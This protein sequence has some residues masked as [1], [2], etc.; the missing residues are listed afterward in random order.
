MEA[1][2]R[3][4]CVKHTETGGCE[5]W[6]E[7]IGLSLRWGWRSERRVG[8]RS[9]KWLGFSGAQSNAAPP[10][11]LAARFI[12]LSFKINF[13]FER[14]RVQKW[15]STSCPRL[16]PVPPLSL[17]FRPLS[18]HCHLPCGELFWNLPLFFLWAALICALW[19]C[20]WLCE[21]WLQ[22]RALMTTFY[23]NVASRLTAHGQVWFTTMRGCVCY[24]KYEE[25]CDVL[26][27]HHL[28]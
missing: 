3:S 10:L 11:T 21:G 2:R 25:T 27:E 19:T 5:I 18:S 8:S 7:I 26:K 14:G 17:L 4:G 28:L 12:L 24:E 23:F 20:C 6:A 22:C 9:F 1:G 13:L 16:L 15:M